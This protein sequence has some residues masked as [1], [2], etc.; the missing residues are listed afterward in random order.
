MDLLGLSAITALN[1][2]VQVDATTRDTKLKEKFPTV[3]HGLGNLREA[4]E[5]KLKLDAK[6]HALFAPMHVP[7]P[8]RNMVLEELN[9][10]EAMG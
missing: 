9:R 3:F 1:L 7:Q 10:M 2:A 6:P 4:Y 8:L 5:I